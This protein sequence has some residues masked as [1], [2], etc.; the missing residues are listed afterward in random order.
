MSLLI[1]SMAHSLSSDAVRPRRYL[2]IRFSAIGDVVLTLPALRA[3]LQRYPDLE[4]V[5]LTRPVLH[6]LF[7]DWSRVTLPEVD[8]KGRHRGLMGMLRLYRELQATDHFD[9]VLDLHDVLRTQVL[10]RLFAWQ[11]TPVFRL[12]K[13]R[14]GRRGMI[15]RQGKVR[16]P[17]QH[18]LS[19][20]V[21]VFR[22]AGLPVHLTPS[23][24]AAISYADH[25]LPVRTDLPR[26]WV[27]VGPFAS[28][29]EKMYPLDRMQVVIEALATQGTTVFLF[30]GPE[31]RAWFAPLVAA[32]P[33]VHLA[34]IDPLAEELALI[35]ALDLMISVD[36]ANT[37]LARLVGTR[38]L[39][40]WGPTHPD[41]GFGPLG[42]VD[43]AD[44]IQVP[45]STLPCRP[46]SIVKQHPCYRGDR[47][48]MHWIEPQQVL[49]RV[50]EVLG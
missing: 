39:S 47:A 49:T 41:A 22:R 33:T 37:H 15:R 26:P 31:D 40:I 34:P 14:K 5:V 23:T 27:G 2:V 43:P 19:N 48:C 18:S 3:A 45:I 46:C 25:P 35:E 29:P 13:D 9:G 30:G 50:R 28:K 4:L 32:H 17:L 44:L 7:A 24:V 36:S 16:Q 1:R 8:L 38:V 20:Y 11:G 10:R 21:E 42:A 6:G 12:R